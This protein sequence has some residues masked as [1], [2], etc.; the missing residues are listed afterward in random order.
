M[1]KFFIGPLIAYF[2]RLRFPTLFA[3]T[4]ALFFLDFV[5]PDFIPFA[6]ELLLGLVAALIASF[7]KR[8]DPK[9]DKD[10]AD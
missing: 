6:D 8:K 4:A 3:I 7:K 10:A 1:S 5:T 9:T 2:A